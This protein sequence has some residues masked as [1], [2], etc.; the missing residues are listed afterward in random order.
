LYKHEPGIKDILDIF[1]Y[2][3]ET[4]NAIDFLNRDQLGV[5]FIKYCDKPDEKIESG[6]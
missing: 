1:D 4:G 6:D 2:V 3:Y 5:S